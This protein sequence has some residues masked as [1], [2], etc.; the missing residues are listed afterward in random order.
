MIQS[1][2]DYM[3][4]WPMFVQLIIILGMFFLFVGVMVVFIY[5]LFKAKEI[6]AGPIE[7]DSAPEEPKA[8]AEK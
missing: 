2:I 5:K 8:D 1:I 6:H 7:I 4:T 3:S